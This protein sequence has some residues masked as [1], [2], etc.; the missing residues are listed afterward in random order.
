MD[1]TKRQEKGQMSI[2]VRGAMT[3]YEASALRKE[4]LECLEDHDSLVLDLEEVSNCDTAGVQVICS[5]IK[6]V[7][8]AGKTFSVRAV[9]AEVVQ[10]AFRAGLDANKGFGPANEV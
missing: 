2:K 8:D 4:L 1:L 7:T 10:A 9:S 6:T 3:I 5:A